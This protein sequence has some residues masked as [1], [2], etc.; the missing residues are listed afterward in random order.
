MGCICDDPAIYDIWSGIQTFLMD[1]GGP[2]DYVFFTNYEAQVCSLVNEHI[3]VARNGPMA[4]VM[5]EEMSPAV[6]TLGMRDVDRD[7]Q[8]VMVVRKDG[9]IIV[10]Y[11]EDLNH[12][13]ILTGSSDSPQADVVP[14]HYLKMQ[15][16]DLG[17][18]DTALG[19]VKALEVLSS[20]NCQQ[21]FQLCPAFCESSFEECKLPSVP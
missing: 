20:T 13:N 17:M 7:F 4:H 3:D 11:L 5:T 12:R 15:L 21:P 6:V 2:F 19:E 8:S 1:R 16:T 9:N 10:H 14:L 18:V